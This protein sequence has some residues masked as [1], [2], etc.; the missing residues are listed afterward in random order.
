MIKRK[1]GLTAEDV[2]RQW[3]LQNGKCPLCDVELARKV[4]V[5]DHDHKT[6]VFRGILDG[7]CNHRVLSMIERGGRRRALGSIV[8]L[9]WAR[10]NAFGLIQ[11]SL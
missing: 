7:W 1:Y 11:A 10:C 6:G 2:A 4:W 8:Y 5:I 3:E 9:G